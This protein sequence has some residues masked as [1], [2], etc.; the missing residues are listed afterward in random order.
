MALA[1]LAVGD[2]DAFHA[3]LEQPGEIGLASAPARARAVRSACR[4]GGEPIKR[5]G[6]RLETLPAWGG[7]S[8]WDK[9]VNPQ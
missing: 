8:L 5:Y 1:L 2:E 3:A 9:T 4:P 6:G 7:A